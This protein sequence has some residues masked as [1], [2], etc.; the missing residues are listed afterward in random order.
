MF[1]WLKIWL[2]HDAK[3]YKRELQVHGHLLQLIQSCQYMLALAHQ[4]PDNPASRQIQ[5]HLQEQWQSLLAK[6][7][8]SEFIIDQYPK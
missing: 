3:A 7:I 6:Q 2:T 5:F 4:L 1:R 8:A